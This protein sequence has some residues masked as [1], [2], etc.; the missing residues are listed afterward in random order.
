MS[1][2]GIN[3]KVQAF[4][5]GLNQLAKWKVE[6]TLVV[7]LVLLVLGGFRSGPCQF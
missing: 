3:V 4:E 2:F 6:L 1:V 5:E 7:S